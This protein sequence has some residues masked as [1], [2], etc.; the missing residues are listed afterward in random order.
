MNTGGG[1]AVVVADEAPGAALYIK[2]GWCPIPVPAGSKNPSR[3]GWQDERHTEA[4]IKRVFAPSGNVG[5]LT[6]APSNGLLDI[7]LD[8][9]EAIEAARYFLPATDMRHGRFSKPS[10]H[11]WYHVADAADFRI[12]KFVDPTRKT[13]NGRACCLVELRGAGHQTVIPPSIHETG[14]P[15]TWEANGEPGQVM[16]G[17]LRAA[18]AKVA[19]CALLAWRWPEGARHDAALALS[20]LLLRGGMTEPD[21]ERFVEAVV[22]VAGDSE[23]SDRVQAMRDTVP[24]LTAGKPTTGGPR[25]AELLP[26]GKAVVGK[27]RD[28]LRLTGTS[29]E[30]SDPLPLIA[31]LEQ[32]PYP[33]D[34]LP[35]CIRQ[36]VVEV[37]GFVKAPVPLVAQ[38][39][40]S[41]ISLAVQ[42]HIDVERAPRLRGPSG[43]YLLSIADSGERKSTI[44]DYFVD[45]I[46]AYELNQ[47]TILQTAIEDYRAN[48]DAWQAKRNGLLDKIRSARKS[49]RHAEEEAAQAALRDL[50]HNQPKAPKVPKLL[51]GDDTPENLAWEL[52]QRWPSAAVLLS[53][54]GLIFGAHGMGR[55]SIMRNLAL[56]NILW[57]GKPHE[58]GRRRSESFTVRGARF[59][60]GLMVQEKPLRIFFEDGG[61]LARG[62]GWFARFLIAW[63]ASTQGYR[64]YAEPPEHWPHLA[65]FHSRLREILE[66]PVQMDEYEILTPRRLPLSAPAKAAWINYH[67]LIESQLR[68][69][70]ELYDVRDVAS[71]SAENAARLAALF[72]FFEH[73]ATPVSVDAFERAS[74]IAAWHLNE[75]RRFFGELALPAEVSNAMRLDAWLLT[76]C[77]RERTQTVPVSVA[78]KSGPSGLRGRAAIEHTVS[79]LAKLHRARLS[80]SGHARHIEVNPALLGTTATTAKTATAMVQS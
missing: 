3:K 29:A 56:L 34:A 49:D 40:L 44:D 41:A 2:R 26:D 23:W 10:S 55:D 8:A 14:E 63:P 6:G 1:M 76:Y 72:H 15:I 50:E 71:K 65:A 57:D 9:A 61:V 31:T 62:I 79:E 22:R 33:L 80:Q 74:R 64:P 28:W 45:P 20:G 78:Q 30:W 52:S 67:D 21:A 4:D 5:L 11:W 16:L 66:Q 68:E 24:E 25:L 69:G 77:Q 48:T 42:A 39:A 7:D 46:I 58:V 60:L 35:T 27:L 36:A 37:Q 17:E 59:T 75:S 54:G 51:R 13:D 18:V 32:V 43:L 53:E 12:E 47:T 38:S 70:G 19:S 73:G